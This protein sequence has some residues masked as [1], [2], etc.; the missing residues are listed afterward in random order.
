MVGQMQQRQL[1]RRVGALQLF[2]P[3]PY[4]RC[5]VAGVEKQPFRGALNALLRGVQPLELLFERWPWHLHGHGREAGAGAGEGGDE[6]EGSRGPS[7]T[8]QLWAPKLI[9]DGG[10]DLRQRTSAAL[11]MHTP[12]KTAA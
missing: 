7:R 10:R 6:E 9:V 2:I 5:G 3:H 4:D 8:V 12:V 11:C 1:A